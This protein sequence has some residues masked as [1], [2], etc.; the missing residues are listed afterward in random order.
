M[1]GFKVISSCIWSPGVMQYLDLASTLFPSRKPKDL[2][3]RPQDGYRKHF[4]PITTM[5]PGDSIVL[6]VP[7]NTTPPRVPSTWQLMLCVPG[8]PG[9]QKLAS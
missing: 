9:C 4:V 1:E 3:S 2:S 7:H 5:R 6:P 8:S